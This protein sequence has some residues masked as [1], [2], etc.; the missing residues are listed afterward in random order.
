MLSPMDDF[1]VHQIADTIDH[2]GTSDPRFQD[3]F[4]FTVHG[5]GGEFLLDVGL[6]AF[7]NQS[8]MDGFVQLMAGH[9]QYNVRVARP[10]N[11]DRQEMFAG[12]LRVEVLEPMRRWRL[13]MAPN[14][15]GVEFE[16]TFTARG[17]A[18][19]H[20]PIFRR[21]N[22]YVAHHQQHYQQAGDFEGWVM[23]E[24]KVVSV[25]D[26]WGL[27]DRSWGVRGPLPGTRLEEADHAAPW[28]WIACQFP[29]HAI[30]G[31][32]GKSEDGGNA[33]VDGAVTYVDGGVGPSF[34][35]WSFDVGRDPLLKF[36]I[37]CAD[38]REEQLEFLKPH[39][40][41]NM[42]GGGYYDGF[43]GA[44]RTATHVE[45]EIWDMRRPEHLRRTA[46][47]EFLCDL[48]HGGAGGIGMIQSNLLQPQHVFGDV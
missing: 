15:I 8:V 44:K 13:S 20:R 42:R 7:P 14:E 31:W 24:G 25:G 26:L 2:V 39:L 33:N 38:G 6:G 30:L 17:A 29:D 45:G 27:R 4:F 47:A 16:L 43:F 22:N 3:R 19:E 21:A 9:R 11:H 41:R 18:Y 40:Y 1:L 37:T 28:A 35:D 32:L 23:A 48:R 10:L 36:K 5:R 12:P 34:V 46:G